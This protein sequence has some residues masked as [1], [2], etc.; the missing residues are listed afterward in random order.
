MPFTA[1]MRPYT[2]QDI[3]SLN[4]NQ[5]GVYGIFRSTIAVYIGSGDIKER[6]LAH[7]N[8]DNSCITANTPNQWT[9]EIVSGDPT[10]RERELIQEYDPICNKRI[11]Q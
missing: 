9:A 5:N 1:K 7:I 4:P 10:R 6:M 8:G 2:K 3:E 11:P